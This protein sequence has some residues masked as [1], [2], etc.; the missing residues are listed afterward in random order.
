M[1]GTRFVTFA[2]VDIRQS[3]AL[4]KPFANIRDQA[5][6]V[7]R[8]ADVELDWWTHRVRR[9]TQLIRLSPLDIRLLKFLMEC[10]GRVFTRQEILQGAWP[11][12]VFVTERT[13]DAH[14][15]TLRKAL[16]KFG[17]PEVV[18]TVRSR[19]YSLD[20]DL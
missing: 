4:A 17:Q 19:G 5:I 13:V 15:V 9:G 6:G 12:N 3:E 14:I 18:R 20:I 1:S 7:L 8:F 16:G 2:S 10:P 11:S